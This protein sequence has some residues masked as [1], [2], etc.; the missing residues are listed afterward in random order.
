MDEP[1]KNVDGDAK[2][3]D[4]FNDVQAVFRAE[5]DDQPATINIS[6]TLVPVD[7]VVDQLPS[8]T[9]YSKYLIT[10]DVHSLWAR[11]FYKGICW[12]R[13]QW[14]LSQQNKLAML[15]P[16]VLQMFLEGKDFH[17]IKTKLKVRQIKSAEI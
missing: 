13:R 5:K 6:T 12:A 11:V 9:T 17:N 8:G 1:V 7:K 2:K 15:H 14:K 3:N 10:D 4:T 16:H